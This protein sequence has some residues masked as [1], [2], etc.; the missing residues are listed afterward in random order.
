MNHPT[1]PQQ[2]FERAK[3]H[4]LDGLESLGKERLEEAEQSFSAS[5]ALLPD[6]AST[7]INLAAVRVRLSRPQDALDTVETL[8]RLEPQNAEAWFHRAEALAQ[9][10]RSEEA[11]QSFRQAGELNPAAMPWYRHG[12]VLQSLDRHEQ[13][14]HSY[15]RALAAD[16]TFAPAW[17]NKGNILREMSRLPEAAQA[18]REAVKHGGADELNAYYLASVTPGGGGAGA[19]ASP[20]SYVEGLFDAYAD[21]FDHHIVD[22]LGYRA[23]E[24]LANELIRLTRSRRFHSALDLGCGTG[25]CGALLKDVCDRM[26][27]VDLSSQMLAKAQA[28]G[29]YEQLVHGDIDGFLRS[30]TDRHDLVV[31]G[32]VFIY[33]GDLESIF[34]SVGRAVPSDGMFCFSLEVLPSNKDMDF[35]LQPSL[36]FAHSEH[37][38]RRLAEANGFEVVQALRA[39]LRQ[40]QRQAIE[41]L[42]V[43]LRKRPA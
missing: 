3:Q 19:A 20:A 10:G 25:L 11:L 32:D 24:V 36:R 29:C 13:A 34:T 2:S 27:G 4:F 31:A 30:N 23:H 16:A 40:D 42:F 28:T 6:R 17:T 18:F 22:V 1:E 15:E 37:Y 8:L 39:P 35:E 33:I 26:A 12:Q 5:L 38:A 43:F 9:L 14:L 7:L 41:G 21:D